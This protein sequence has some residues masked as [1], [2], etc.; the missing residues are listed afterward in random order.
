MFLVKIQIVFLYPGITKVELK[1]VEP[2]FILRYPHKTY[3]SLLHIVF[4]GGGGGD[5]E[6]LVHDAHFG[7]MRFRLADCPADVLLI[8]MT[9]LN[10][11]VKDSDVTI[12]GYKI[13]R[14]NRVINGGYSGGVS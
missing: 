3:I 2:C 8:T 6:H 12:L 9:R 13:I 11:L 5:R 14:Q 4:W 7:E 1:T 10:D